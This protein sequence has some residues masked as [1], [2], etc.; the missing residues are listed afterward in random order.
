M[1]VISELTGTIAMVLAL[2]ANTLSKIRKLEVW[3]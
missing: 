2:Y 1:G 3:G